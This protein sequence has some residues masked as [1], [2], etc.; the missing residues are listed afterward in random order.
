MAYRLDAYVL[1]PDSPPSRLARTEVPT[2]CF[3]AIAL[4]ANFVIFPE[5][6]NSSYTTDL[7]DKFLIPIY[8]RSKLHSRLLSTTPP[9]KDGGNEAWK[10]LDG[11]FESTQQQMSASLEGLLG[12]VA[13]MELEVSMGRLS[14]QDLKRLTAKL[15]EVLSRSMG[16]GVLYRTVSRQH[17]VRSP[18]SREGVSR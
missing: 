5:T 13:M 16:L 7:V 9:T 14:A 6:L 4:V 11:E 2:A 10:A 18:S 15:H 1:R 17:R 8:S 3:I 12:S